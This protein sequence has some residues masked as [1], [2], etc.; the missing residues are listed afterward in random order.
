M[1]GRN[2]HLNDYELK[3][4]ESLSQAVLHS[5][6]RRS[7]LILYFWLLTVVFFLL[8]ASI[9]KVDEIVRAE[10][11]IVPSGEN[12]M[13]QNLEGGII[14]EI[15]V[16]EGAAV[17]KGDVL[18]KIKNLKSKSELAGYLSKYYELAAKATRLKAQA[19]HRSLKFDEV[20][21]KEH[22]ELVARETSLYHA[23]MGRL[24]AQINTLEKQIYQKKEQLHEA[25]A[26]LK[27]LER[28]YALIE[29]EVKMSE[30]MVREGVKSKVDF[31]KLQREANAIRTEI[32]SVK[33]TIPRIKSAIAEIESRI[34]EVKLEFESKSE[35]EMNEAL[36]EMERLTE[37]IKAFQDSVRRLLVRSPVDGLVKKLYVNTI[38][39]VV[40]SGMDLVEI[41]PL[42]KNLI[43]EVKVSPKDIAF[44]YPG[45]KALVKF[46][47][48]DFAIY[49]GLTGKVVGISPDTVTDKKDRTFYIVRIETSDN[50]LVLNGQRLKI[51]P[52]MVVNVDIITG[53]RTILDY[54]LKPM[55]NSKDYIFTEH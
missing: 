40:R 52:G 26:K 14:E 37:K 1:A 51:I 23:N 22:P 36:G 28:S 43:A 41:V 4:L 46:T 31:L 50:N 27:N 35:K 55:L 47:A 39:G 9:A 10:G 18:L 15:A 33:I 24:K 8:W 44:I 13:L 12:K 42:D 30:P 2:E 17:K 7:R 49:G 20:L 53:K 48:Y 5:T 34:K 21:K 16:K 19:K 3:Y 38:G 29:E 11:K 54:L 45:Q 25:Q 32:D 6:P